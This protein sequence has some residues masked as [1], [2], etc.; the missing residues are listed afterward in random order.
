M[1]NIRNV[2]IAI[3]TL[4][5]F[6]FSCLVVL[7]DDTNLLYTTGFE[8]PDY[9]QG[10][11]WGQD[12]W[13]DTYS[14]DRVILVTNITPATGTQS[15][16]IKEAGNGGGARDFVMPENAIVTYALKVRF[17]GS[18]DPG[19]YFWVIAGLGDFWIKTDGASHYPGFRTQDGSEVNFPLLTCSND[20]WVDYH[21]TADY[22][23][24][25]ILSVG[26]AGA[27]TNLG[28]GIPTHSSVSKTT[29][30]RLCRY[31]TGDART[32][33][34]DL[35][36]TYTPRHNEASLLVSD[37]TKL[38][39]RTDLTGSIQIYND[40]KQDI[41]F[42]AQVTAGT[43]WLTLTDTSGTFTYRK[44]LG[45]TIDRTK[46]DEGMYYGTI[47]IDA[48]SAGTETVTIIV[49][50]G[51][52]YFATGFEEPF[53]VPGDLHD[54]DGWVDGVREIG[55]G[56][57]ELNVTNVNAYAG[58]QCGWIVDS[59]WYGYYH[60]VSIDDNEI[61]T[62][63]AM[64]RYDSAFTGRGN[65]YFLI[66]RD[67]THIGD[68]MLVQNGDDMLYPQFY[69]SGGLATFT[70]LLAPQDEWF[71]YGYTIDWKIKK[72]LA[73]HFDGETI[74]L[75]SY[76]YSTTQPTFD[77]PNRIWICGEK[78]SGENAGIEIDDL[79]LYREP[80]PSGA[81]LVIEKT[82][83]VIPANT[84]RGSI[85]LMNGG[86]S[87]YSYTAT[88]LSGNS[89][90]SLDKTSG[91]VI[92]EDTIGF[93][94][95]RSQMGDDMYYG[96]VYINAGDAGDG[97]VDIIVPN[98]TVVYA[99]GFEPPVFE[100]GDLSGQ[101]GWESQ[102]GC[103]MDVTN[104]TPHAGEQCAWIRDAWWRGYWCPYEPLNAGDMEI[105][106]YRAW[107]KV[108]SDTE[109]TDH[110]YMNSMLSDVYLQRDE[111]NSEL[112]PCVLTASG[113]MQFPGLAVPMD[114]WIEFAYTLDFKFGLIRS[115]E[116]NGVTQYLANAFV[117]W[118]E[119]TSD[120]LHFDC[121]SNG[122]DSKVQIDDV[123]VERVTGTAGGALMVY[124]E[125]VE[126]GENVQT[127]TMLYNTSTSSVSFTTSSGAAWLQ[128]SPASGNF[129]T[130]T[131]LTFT[132]TRAGLSPGYYSTYAVI[133]GG[134]AGV[135]SCYVGMAVAQIWYTCDFE[136][137]KFVPGNLGRQ[138]G[139]VNA[140]TI[141][142][143]GMVTNCPG[144]R[145]GQCVRIDQAY[146]FWGFFHD[147][148][149]PDV[150]DIT[151]SMDL[152]V[153]GENASH[154]FTM[155]TREPEK[156]YM[157]ITQANNEVGLQIEDNPEWQFEPADADTWFNFQFD[158]DFIKQEVKRLQ[159][160]DDEYM[161]SNVFLRNYDD[162]RFKAIALINAV[163]TN[164]P[165]EIY[166]D[167]IYVGAPVPEASGFVMLL[168]ILCLGGIG[169]RRR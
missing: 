152:Y 60:T 103:V 127:N 62:Y 19:E 55:Q 111:D 135:V 95:D 14:Q 18:S 11:L 97:N 76:N 71:D 131:P 87:E 163:Y 59:W 29:R 143:I 12:G 58:D 110:I 150:R 27:N 45:F 52:T 98:G 1:K 39:G 30:L 82:S 118:P 125:N 167:N 93:T 134:E 74:D 88:V 75:S 49:P 90:L 99:T 149:M 168:M 137:P 16:W 85:V 94:V 83:M 100:N 121:W 43:T 107:I 28:T 42:T 80:R 114:E 165:C 26:L 48:G 72:V 132:A 84:N 126:L 5:V 166:I 51:N 153:P 40:G 108:N 128:V 130:Q 6:L 92:D 9:S 169:N 136:A 7:A 91:L 54:Q 102:A 25:K 64:F 155:V 119:N 106:R 86:T 123:L 33:V 2:P 53:Y 159:Y 120:G 138:Q 162:N 34:D 129:D 17:N 3:L 13:Y 46:I 81:E 10:L 154:Y 96:R 105:M 133:D 148:G 109:V 115:L 36:I 65:T 141:F 112:I 139:W 122:S 50:G 23:N 117:A 79:Q 156:T 77:A 31:S 61:T 32:Q 151:I 24:A 78:G 38:L 161:I 68:Y 4:L 67:G 124:P 35:A 21:I 69:H 63:K 101:G 158:M 146:Q 160:N 44:E 142:N 37:T 104:V 66:G 73:L 20:E 140:D 56:P 57:L 145:A 8:P 147:V 70:N 113:L 41:T 89:W 157:V 116:I 164:E 47:E 22:L 15:A 144:G